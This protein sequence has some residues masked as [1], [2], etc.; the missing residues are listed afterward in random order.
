MSPAKVPPKM[1]QGLGKMIFNSASG[2]LH[3]PCDLL[4]IKP[5]VV[6]QAENLSFLRGQLLQGFFYHQPEVCCIK[7][8][9]YLIIT[10]LQLLFYCGDQACFP[11]HLTEVIDGLVAGHGKNVSLG[12]VQR[13][14]GGAGFPKFDEDILDDL[15]GDCTRFTQFENIRGEAV[16]IGVVERSKCFLISFCDLLQ[17]VLLLI[18]R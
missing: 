15:F 10:C 11:G 5:F 2:K 9:F 14:Q 6:A 1:L 18:W 13:H 7:P 17:K 8:V 3:D 12:R 4:V 16:K